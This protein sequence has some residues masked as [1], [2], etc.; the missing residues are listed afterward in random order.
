LDRRRTTGTTRRK[1]RTGNRPKSDFDPIPE[2]KMN[3]GKDKIILREDISTYFVDQ[4]YSEV[5]ENL[6]CLC[7]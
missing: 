4:R 5:L 2:L 7:P 3:S 6:I 1:R